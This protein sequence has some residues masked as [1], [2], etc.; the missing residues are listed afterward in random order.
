MLIVCGDS[1]TCTQGAVGAMAWGIGSTEVRNVLI[2][3]TIIQKRAKRMRLNIEGELNPWVSAKDIILY[4]IGEFGADAGIGY[5]VEYAGPTVRAMTMEERLVLCNLSIE[6]GSRVGMVAPDET[7]Y[8]YLEGRQFSPRGDYWDEALRHWQTLPSDPDAQFDRE[9][10]IDASLIEP[11]VTWG[12]SPEHV[13]GVSERIPDPAADPQNQVGH[14]VAL[15]YTGLT[16]GDPIAG[17]PIQRVFIGSC[18]NSRISDL[19]VAVRVVEGRR[20]ASHVEAWVIPGSQLVKRQGEAEGLD[21]IFREAGFQ[22]REPG[23][24]LCVAVNGESVA[25]GDHC[26]STSN[27]NFIGRQG[28]DSV[29]HL[30]SPAMAAAAGIAGRIVDVTSFGTRRTGM[31]VLQTIT[32]GDGPSF[33][34]HTGIAAPFLRPN[35]DTDVIMPLN[36]RGASANLSPGEICFESIRYLVDGSE[37][38]DFILNRQPYREGSILL[39]GDNFGTGSSRESAVTGLMAF[40]FRSIVAPS[41]GEIFYTNCFANGMLPVTLGAEV[42]EEIADQVMLDPEVEMTVD[43][44]QNQIQ[45]PGLDAVS[46][47]IDPRL[48]NKMLLGLRDLDEILR[49]SNET[50]AFEN[51]DRRN[52]PWIYEWR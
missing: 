33:V 35:V 13:V 26:V 24:S 22:W 52:R 37:N 44:E 5:A 2:S 23:C 11:Q 28:R 31:R 39:A 32:R 49:Y 16:P 17:T 36:R 9:E 50:D 42:I 1:H 6:M 40:G 4:A 8:E 29:T 18:A 41:F 48:R 34:S 15:D 27:R 43:L 7:T 20:V 14:R 30:A 51:E 19:R 47:S 3:Q 25:P 10:T 12:T 45:R 46:F 38:P 21:R